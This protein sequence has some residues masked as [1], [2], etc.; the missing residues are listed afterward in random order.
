MAGTAQVS[1]QG[2]RARVWTTVQLWWM[3]RRETYQ[4]ASTELPSPGTSG[5]GRRGSV[6]M[7]LHLLHTDGHTLTHRQECARQCTHR[8]VNGSAH[9]TCVARAT[10]QATAQTRDGACSSAWH[11]SNLE[12]TFRSIHQSCRTCSTCTSDRNGLPRL[13]QL[14]MM[15]LAALIDPPL[16]LHIALHIHIPHAFPE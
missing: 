3:V 2:L 15:S 7:L 6:H 12:A 13:Q 16:L 11:G 10:A 14:P 1:E 8:H 4:C 5:R 9:G